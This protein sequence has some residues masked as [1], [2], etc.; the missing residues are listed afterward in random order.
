MRVLLNRRDERGAVTLIVTFFIVAMCICAAMV[1]DFGMAYLNKQ[2]AQGAADAA[3]M[4]AGK[5]FVGQSGT[6]ASLMSDAGLMD[7]ANSAADQLRLANLPGSPDVNLV[8]SCATGVLTLDYHVTTTSPLG[9]GQMVTGTDH[10]NVDREAEASLQIVTTTV[11]ACSLCFLGTGQ[12]STGNADYQVNGG[13]IHLNGSLSAGPNGMWTANSIG[14]A[15]TASGGQFSPAWKTEPQIP[16]PLGSLQMP[17]L[18]TGLS[19]KSNPCTDGPGI[20]GAFPIPKGVCT[21]QPGAY[22]ITGSWSMKNNS[23]LTSSGGVTLY[24]QSPSGMLD[25]K[26]GTIDNL[27]APTGSPSGAP[28]GWP[29]GLAI[30]YDRNNTNPITAQGNG[31]TAVAGGI[32]AKSATIDFNGGSTFLINGGPVVVNGATGNGNPGAVI[33]DHANDIGGTQQSN[34]S[35]T[36]MTK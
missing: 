19:P 13:S 24:F 8:P 16:D 14:L 27:T 4:A 3:V 23:T 36:T 34:A 5:V 35:T 1:T 20:Y 12:M 25:V 10:L 17:L 30:I 9:L 22:A 18:T 28:P 7:S 33:V 2:Q 21:L 31:G 26:N 11:G 29:S 32:Y 6:C 15:G